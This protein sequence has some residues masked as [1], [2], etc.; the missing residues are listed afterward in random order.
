MEAMGL[1]NLPFVAGTAIAYGLSPE[2]AL[3]AITL[4]AAA[5]LGIDERLGSLSVG[6]DATLI[7]SRGDALDMRGNDLSL[8]FIQG[9]RIV[10]DDHQKQLYRQYTGRYAK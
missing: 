9:R 4:D 8:A 2:D 7:V 1:R 3:R 5:I 6:K 10:L